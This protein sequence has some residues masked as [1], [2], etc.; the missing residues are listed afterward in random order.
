[1]RLHCFKYYI[2]CINRIDDP[3]LSHVK[4][5]NNLLMIFSERYLSVLFAYNWFILLLNIEHCLDDL[6]ITY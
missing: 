2:V 5:V 4:E 1:M 6:I 3:C